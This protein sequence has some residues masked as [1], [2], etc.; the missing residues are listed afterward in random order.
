MGGGAQTQGVL[1]CATLRTLVAEL[2]GDRAAV[3]HFIS[4]FL[5][6]TDSR[7]ARIEAAVASSDARE[8]AVAA[9]SMRTTSTMVGAHG[10]ASAVLDLERLVAPGGVGCTQFCLDRVRAHVEQVRVALT[11]VLQEHVPIASE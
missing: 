7:L 9:L 10:L 3:R 4:R 6:L 5:E 11:Q 8:A 1:D 2:D